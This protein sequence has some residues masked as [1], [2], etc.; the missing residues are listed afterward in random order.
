MS[1]EESPVV[2]HKTE[3]RIEL[4]IDKLSIVADNCNPDDSDGFA[5]LIIDFGDRDI[6]PA[7]KPP[8]HALDDTPLALERGHSEQR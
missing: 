4:L 6:E 2:A 7:L 5:V 8:D 1:E 3:D